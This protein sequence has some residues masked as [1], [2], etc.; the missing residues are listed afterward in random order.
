MSIP[1]F[2]V[3]LAGKLTEFVRHFLLEKQ[4]DKVPIMIQQEI[5]GAAVEIEKRKGLDLL[6]SR[7][8]HNIER[9]IRLT[10]LTTLGT[11]DSIDRFTDGT[12]NLFL[13]NIRCADHTAKRPSDHEHLRIFQ[14]KL[15]GSVTA[16]RETGERAVIAAIK[17]A[18]AFVDFGNQ[19]LD[20][21]A[22]LFL[23]LLGEIVRIPTVLA[24]DRDNNEIIAGGITDYLR[25]RCPVFKVSRQTM[26]KVEHRIAASAFCLIKVVVREY[27]LIG[28]FSPHQF[29]DEFFGRHLRRRHR[30][31]RL[32]NLSE[33][34]NTYQKR[35][36]QCTDGSFHFLI[37][38]PAKPTAVLIL[39][40]DLCE[41]TS[42]EPNTMTFV[43]HV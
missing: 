39:V 15:D 1:V 13:S 25:S 31:L 34:G 12:R 9:V 11:K 36:Q 10:D 24:F 37:E 38:K 43:A 27:Y 30:R 7:T 32:C 20:D 22:F 14:S 40:D 18:I 3:V 35:N 2:P 29:A 42:I 28:H 5:L 26:Q 33:R 21:V 23:S 8:P 6:R 19:L 16:H 41:L 17:R 4:F